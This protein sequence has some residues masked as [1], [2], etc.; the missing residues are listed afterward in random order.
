[1]SVFWS[2]PVAVRSAWRRQRKPGTS[3]QLD[4]G[5]LY[6]WRHFGS[7]LIDTN[8]IR[9][10]SALP[11]HES[12]ARYVPEPTARPAGSSPSQATSWPPSDMPSSTSVRTTRPATSNTG[13]RTNPAWGRSNLSDV[14][15][16]NGFGQFWESTGTFGDWPAGPTGEAGARSRFR[17]QRGPPLVT[18]RPKE[19]S[20]DNRPS[21]SALASGSSSRSFWRS[22]SRQSRTQPKGLLPQDG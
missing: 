19:A 15:G 8:R 21:V 20:W 18:S 16:L 2:T 3:D 17:G 22:P 4:P 13:S 7:G 6:V 10:V 12:R 14:R 1:M 11:P 9:T 5:P